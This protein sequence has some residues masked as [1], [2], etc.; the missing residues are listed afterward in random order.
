MWQWESIPI[1]RPRKKWWNLPFCSRRTPG[2]WIW[3]LRRTVVDPVLFRHLCSQ[4]VPDG[5]LSAI[6]EADSCFADAHPWIAPRLLS[7]FIVKHYFNGS[8]IH[9]GKWCHL[10]LCLPLRTEWLDFS[11]AG[12]ARSREKFCDVWFSFLD[13]N[14][15]FGK[16]FAQAVA[17]GRITRW[18]ISSKQQVWIMHGY[19]IRFPLWWSILRFWQ[20]KCFAIC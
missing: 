15:N 18:F 3:I 10:D 5:A 2:V 8:W 9:Y 16:Y 6:K 7:D 1:A 12:R 19:A 4:V 13:V 14:V 17:S 20:W 11:A